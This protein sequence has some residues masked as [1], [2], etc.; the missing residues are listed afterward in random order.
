MARIK[1]IVEIV[2]QFIPRVTPKCEGVSEH[3]SC[4]LLD[5][6]RT[7]MSLIELPLLVHGLGIRD[8]RTHFNR[9]PRNSVETTPFGET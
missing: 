7:M 5:M 2:S 8:N 1:D 6:V 3:H 4:T 9:A